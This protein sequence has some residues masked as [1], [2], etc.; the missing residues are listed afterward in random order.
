VGYLS[1]RVSLGPAIALFAA[2]AY[3]IMIVGTVL[4]PE[5]RGK[6]LRAYE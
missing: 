4:L 5:T 6:E 3:L 1:G 2:S